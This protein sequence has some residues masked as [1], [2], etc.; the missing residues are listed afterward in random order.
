MPRDRK[1][2]YQEQKDRWLTY[3]REYEARPE[4][5]E[6]KKAY[7]SSPELSLIHI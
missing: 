6:K 7:R 4:V 2:Y 1:A 5:K 3:Q